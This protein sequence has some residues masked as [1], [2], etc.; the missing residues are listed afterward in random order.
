MAT[1]TAAQVGLSYPKG[2]DCIV[3]VCKINR[4][5]SSTPKMTIPKDAVICGVHVFQDAVAV[6]GNASY[7]LG[8]SGATT[9]I[10][11]AYSL[12]TAGTGLANPGAA[13]G[14]G[15]MTKLTQDQLLIGTF[16]VGTSS[17][18][19]TGYIIVE[20]FMPGGQEQVDD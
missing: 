12:T 11:N 5:D 1:F 14:T 20:Y 8:W 2:R 13:A 19:G 16:T 18:G 3:K 15:I 9:S 17:A 10:L 6:T 4:T 7:N